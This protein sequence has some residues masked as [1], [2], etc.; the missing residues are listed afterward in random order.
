MK[1]NRVIFFTGLLG[2][3]VLGG[4]ASG[5][6]VPVSNFETSRYLGKWYEIAR[7][8]FMFEQGVSNVT[9]EYS[10][11]DNG[12]IKVLNTGYNVA[13]NK[14]QKVTGKAK[15]GAE[16]GTGYLRVSFFGP[17]YSDY[18]ILML[19]DAY[20]YALVAGKNH[21]YLWILS[22]TPDIPDNI[23][24]E[25]VR[26]AESLGFETGKLVWTEHDKI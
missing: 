19:D 13:K 24:T 20:Q 3:S 14:W 1:A 26:H 11:N 23:K 17:F 12:S 7:F 6:F 9:A 22:R 2:C 5:N 21:K 8:D 10:L 16:P 15:A 25:Y 18:R 4:C